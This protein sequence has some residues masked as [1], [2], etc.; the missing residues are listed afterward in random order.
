MAGITVAPYALSNSESSFLLQSDGFVAGTFLDNPANRYQLEGGVVGSAQAPPLWGGIPVTLEVPAPGPGG[1]SS[2]LGSS[3][4]AATTTATNLDGFVVFNQASA[5]VITASSNVPLYPANTS[6]N[7]IRLGCGLWLVLPVNPTAVNTIAG[8]G[9]N[10]AIYWDYTNNRVDVTGTGALGL[11]I[12][13]LNTNS[14]TVT[15]SGGDATW[16]SGGSVIVVRV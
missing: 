14:K 1:A 16:T 8:G 12:I 9:S 13:A 4:I 10:Q 6:V 15:Y 5:G 2:G 3:V 7:F 11:Q